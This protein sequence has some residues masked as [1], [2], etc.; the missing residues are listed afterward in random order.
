M[1]ELYGKEEAVSITPMKWK[2]FFW[3]MNLDRSRVFMD[4]I[5]VIPGKYLPAVVSAMFLLKVSVIITHEYNHE[6]NL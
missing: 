1:D 6:Q 5:E 3:I 2:I 4:Q